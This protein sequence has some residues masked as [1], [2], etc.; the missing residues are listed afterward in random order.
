MAAC[1][2]GNTTNPKAYVGVVGDSITWY[3]ESSIEASLSSYAYDIEAYPG[4]RIDQMLPQIENMADNGSNDAPAPQ[5]WIL[6]LGT[7]DASQDYTGWQASFDQMV[8]DTAYAQ[9]VIFVTIN[10]DADTIGGSNIAA[11][12]DAEIEHL[13]TTDP[14]KYLYIDW[15]GL[16]NQNAGML[17][18]DGIHPDA[19]GQQELASWYT[20]AL[21]A[22]P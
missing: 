12:E 10:T 4:A 15:N 19:S 18:P 11:T 8:A 13:H 16:L 5:D 17:Q 9:C 7:N 3:S 22:C 20:L 1:Y 21:S 14:R 6:N 2:S